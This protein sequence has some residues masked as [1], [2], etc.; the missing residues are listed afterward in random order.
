LYFI[1]W[2]DLL[3]PKPSWAEKLLRPVLVYVSLLIIFRLISKRDLAQATLFD[4]LIILLISNV[5]QNAMIGDDN[6]VLGAGAGAVMLILIAGALNRLTSRN[7]RARVLLEGNPQLL[8]SHGKILD[9]Q[10][11]KSNVSHN[12]LLAAIRK[13]GI[14]RLS[15]VSFAILELDGTISVIKKDNGN[16]TFDCLPV[17]IV[18]DVSLDDCK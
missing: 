14:A 4:F 9:E 18:G 11:H 12:D 3:M 2:H 10:M 16:R 13:Q 17:E 5:V 6:S 7:R 15:D 8:V 1:N